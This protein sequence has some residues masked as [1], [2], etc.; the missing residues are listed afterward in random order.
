Y[1]IGQR[2]GIGVNEKGTNNEPLYV[3]RLDAQAKRVYVGPREALARDHVTLREMN[4]LG[5][6]G[7][8]MQN[9]AVDVKL[10]SMTQAAPAL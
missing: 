5:R 4:W 8:T 7:E 10:R 9:I 2:R 3:V 1:T 6:P